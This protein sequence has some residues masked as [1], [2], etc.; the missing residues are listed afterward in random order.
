M[1]TKQQVERV[2]IIF[3]IKLSEEGAVPGDIH[4]LPIGAWDHPVYGKIVINQNDIQEFIQNFEAGLRKGI[5]VTAGHEAIDEKPAVGWVKEL[6]A[7]GDGLGAKVEW[8]E[9]GKELLKNKKFKYFSPEFY[10]EYED[11]ETREIYKNVFT[12]GALTNKPYFKGLEAIVLSEH[13]IKKLNENTMNIEE[14]LQKKKED[15][16]AEEVEFLKGQNQDELTDEQKEKTNELLKDDDEGEGEGEEGAGEGE[17][18]DEG[19][20]ASGEKE[21]AGGTGETQGTEKKIQVDASY[22]KTLESKANEGQQ[23]FIQ[24]KEMQ[25]KNDVNEMTFNEKNKDGKFLPKTAPKLKSFLEK[26]TPEQYSSF[27][28]LVEEL[29]KVN[30]FEEL[31]DSQAAE[32]DPS[33]QVDKL[34]EKKMKDDSA[35]KYSD[36]LREVLAENPKLVTERESHLQGE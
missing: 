36:A 7:R 19:S 26:L 31:G 33:K 35:M 1:K 24:M 15:L 32:N 22:L 25:V 17:G 3:P 21:G 30:I 13:T 11:P 10:R 28:A 4:V 27:K 34:V 20:S 16:T 18:G 6:Y 5:S 14:L 12:G 2:P 29:P 23:A 9:E 8:N